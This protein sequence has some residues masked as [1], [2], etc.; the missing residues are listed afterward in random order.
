MSLRYEPPTKRTGHESEYEPA[1]EP[2]ADGA[3][4]AGGA[5]V[6]LMVKSPAGSR[7]QRGDVPVSG[8]PGT[9][10]LR[11]QVMVQEAVQEV[12]PLLVDC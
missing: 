4:P 10:P 6:E 3:S 12:V 2:Q 8:K 5:A 11:N 9:S 7:V 1:S